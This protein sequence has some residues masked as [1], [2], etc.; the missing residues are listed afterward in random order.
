MEG[1]VAVR[2]RFWCGECG[3]R[4]P[5]GDEAEG[6]LALVRHCRRWHAG[7]AVGGQRER[8]R[9]RTDGWGGCLPAL[10]AVLLLV[11]A[12]ALVGLVLAA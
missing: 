12:L 11:V 3:F 5:W 10:C 7:V 6:R 1:S 4:T 8:A 2:Y 9:G